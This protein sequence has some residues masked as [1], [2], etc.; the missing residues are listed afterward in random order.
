MEHMPAVE[1]VRTQVARLANRI[2]LT[3]AAV[4]ARAAAPN[5]GLP[6]RERLSVGI[7]RP[8]QPHDESGFCR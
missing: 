1:E 6:K 8:L 7:A 5:N 3:E 4:T 2:V